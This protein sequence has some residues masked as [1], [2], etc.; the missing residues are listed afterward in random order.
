[1]RRIVLKATIDR[2]PVAADFK[3]VEAGRPTCPENGV[4]ARV[5]YLSLDPYVGSRLRGRH[6][7]EAP[8]RPMLDAIPGA[9][10]GVIVESRAPGLCEGDLIQSMEGAWAEYVALESHACRR[11][12]PRAA[13]LSAHLGPLGMPGLTAWAG[14]SRLACVDSGET[15]L[16]DAAAGAVGGAAGQIARILG[17][18]KV[19]GIAG[20]EVKLRL[21]EREYG[22]DAGVDYKSPDWRAALADALG[23]GLDVFFENVSTEMA[24]IALSH[25]RP[26]ARGVLC[27]LAAHYQDTERSAHAL[28]AGLIIAK[29]A[30]LMGLVVYDFYHCWDEFAAMATDWVRDGRLKVAEDRAKGLEGAPALFEKLMA[31]RNVGK[32]IVAVDGEPS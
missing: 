7:G 10:V 11:I 17:A 21:V 18:G 19:V 2:R 5:L 25:A 8:P 12:D 15:F 13:P 29:R 4:V 28:N 20:G 9:I 30:R 22:F 16:V 23:E 14:V 31:G 6:M 32:C 1:M 3:L 24:M 26:Y 27:G